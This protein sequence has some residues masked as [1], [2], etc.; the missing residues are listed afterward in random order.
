MEITEK[1]YI[2]KLFDILKDK[3]SNNLQKLFN[4]KD[5]FTIRKTLGIFGYFFKKIF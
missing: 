3:F 1:I 4:N 2:Y 5:N